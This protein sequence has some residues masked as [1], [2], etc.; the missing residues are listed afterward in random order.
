[1]VANHAWS[2]TRP[3][4]HP[5]K[6][7]HPTVADV[8]QAVSTQLCTACVADMSIAHKR[9]KVA[10]APCA[11]VPFSLQS[12]A[13]KAATFFRVLAK[14]GS[15]AVPQTLRAAT[16]EAYLARWSAL[17]THAAQAPFAASLVLQDPTAQTG[18]DG[19]ARSASCWNTP[20]TP[21]RHPA[22][23]PAYY[24]PPPKETFMQQKGAWKKNMFLLWL[25]CKILKLGHYAV[26]TTTHALQALRAF[27][28]GWILRLDVR[29]KQVRLCEKS[30][31]ILKFVQRA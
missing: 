23:R 13:C 29:S 30:Q 3:S 22:S 20:R 27:L 1:M 24:E 31:S 18:P 10:P 21:P 4:Q 8:L 12:Q 9:I 25:Q 28:A 7:F 11:L 14:A 26:A 17:L 16:T 5:K 15:R 6:I 2:L 19:N